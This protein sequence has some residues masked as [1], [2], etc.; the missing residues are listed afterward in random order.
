MFPYQDPKK[1]IEE[2]VEDLLQRMTLEEKIMQTDQ[3]AAYYFAENDTDGFVKELH[4]ALCGG[5]NP[6]WHPVPV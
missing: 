2:R 5:K 3:H 6:S 1:N 4:S